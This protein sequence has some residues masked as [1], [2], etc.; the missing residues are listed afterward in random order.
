M[1]VRWKKDGATIMEERW[2]KIL[3]KS[4]T[5]ENINKTFKKERGFIDKIIELNPFAIAI[6]DKKGSYVKVNQAFL[7]LFK[8]VPPKDYSFIKNLVLITNGSLETM[9]KLKEG[10]IISYPARDYNPRN[11]PESYPNINFALRII[12][13][14]IMDENNELEFVASMTQNIT[15]LKQ[16]QEELELALQSSSIISII[17]S[18]L[19][20]DISKLDE[21]IND[22]FNTLGRALNANYCAILRHVNGDSGK[23]FKIRSLWTLPQNAQTFQNVEEILKRIYLS[24]FS[25]EVPL[26]FYFKIDIATV[27]K[28][29][30][31][32]MKMSNLEIVL[33]IP[34][35]V[36]SGRYGTL[37]INRESHW[38][39]FSDNEV[40][41]ALGAGVII[42]LALMN[43]TKQ[44]DI[45]DILESISKLDIGTCVVQNDA[46]NIPRLKYF[47][48]KFKAIYGFDD[49]K[50]K[51]AETFKD[52]ISLEDVSYIEKLYIARQAGQT[53]PNLYR[54]DIKTAF[55]IK[56]V[57]L[58][59]II[60]LFE[61][62]VA[63][64]CCLI[65]IPQEEL[66]TPK[67]I[68]NAL[69]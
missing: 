9:A 69:T 43:E 8:T 52:F 36:G 34:I 25:E 21:N 19:I 35:I 51:A 10:E 37:V 11:H 12:N 55:G 44:Q 33:M 59:I 6:F 22:G 50:L 54:V 48:A 24:H 42:G 15:D 30:A 4:T 66:K 23:E 62:K 2:R 57:Q 32:E 49:Q 5:T 28:K 27:S 46:Q 40:K 31:S 1:E 13:F 68:F 47:N 61:N 18:I 29:I 65:E 67:E 56:H 38:K 7:K 41:T 14:P 58:G 53:I 20:Q 39:D 17:A 63:S 60:G 26:D 3:E 64:Y 16:T 45:Q